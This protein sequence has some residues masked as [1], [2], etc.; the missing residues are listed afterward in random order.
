MFESVHDASRALNDDKLSTVVDQFLNEY[1]ECLQH[2]FVGKDCGSGDNSWERL[3]KA[4]AIVIKVV[5][6]DAKLNASSGLDDVGNKEKKLNQK[7][8]EPMTDFAEVFNDTT[9]PHI[10]DESDTQSLFDARAEFEA[11]LKA[12]EFYLG[13]HIAMVTNIDYGGDCCY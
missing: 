3:E 12:A 4:S 8:E 11:A 2:G 9:A 10:E 6:R 5:K 1:Y 7:K 13:K